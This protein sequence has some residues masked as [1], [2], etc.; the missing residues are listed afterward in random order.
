VPIAAVDLGKCGKLTFRVVG[1]N[2]F[3]DPNRVETAERTSAANNVEVI[4]DGFS[5]AKQEVFP[6]VSGKNENPAAGSAVARCAKKNRG[7]SADQS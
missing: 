3:H 2:T 1:R 5:R 4:L 6:S 7:L